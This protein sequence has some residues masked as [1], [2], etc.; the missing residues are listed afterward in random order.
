MVRQALDESALVGLDTETTGLDPRKDRVRLLSLAT[1][2]GLYLVDCFAADPRPLWDV[3]AEKTLV[4]HNLAFD[5]LMLGGL[6]FALTAPAQDTMILSPILTA[7]LLN[8]R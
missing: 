3:L 6:G 1:D 2:R 7:G 5:L 8:A 4:G